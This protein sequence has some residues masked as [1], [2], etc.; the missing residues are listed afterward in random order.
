MDLLEESSERR[1][2]HVRLGVSYAALGH[3]GRRVITE[4]PL[5]IDESL[6]LLLSSALR[7]KGIRVADWRSVF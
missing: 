4:I 2:E 6:I 5:F 1:Q 7:S 3:E